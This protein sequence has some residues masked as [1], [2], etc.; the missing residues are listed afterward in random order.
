MLWSA[1]RSTLRRQLQ[2]VTAQAWQD[3]NLDVY[4]QI[5]L[6]ILQK[7][8]LK[9]DRMAF[10]A[11]ETVNLVAGTTDYTLATATPD[12]HLGIM[13]VERRSS[14]T[15]SY[16]K[17]TRR[18]LDIIR[19]SILLGT[20]SDQPEGGLYAVS[21]LST[22]VI[23]PA[24]SSAISAGLRVH[25]IPVLT[26]GSDSASPQLPSPLHWSIILLAKAA[27]LGETWQETGLVEK[28][29]AEIIGD[30]PLYFSRDDGENPQLRPDGIH[31]GQ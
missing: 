30:L 11:T 18:D 15:T 3:V 14:T 7:E 21:A 1:I 31:T 5:A 24:P 10:R 8:I 13:L 22:I 9:I 23:Y 2:E 26:Q 4:L 16:V 20:S 6:S 12:A 28:R 27:A 29:I 19:D 17:Q 25:Y